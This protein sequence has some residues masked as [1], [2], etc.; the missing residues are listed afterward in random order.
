[1]TNLLKAY[2]HSCEMPE[3]LQKSQRWHHI[4]VSEK[5]TKQDFSH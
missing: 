3:C 4:I 2:R 5:A 1:M